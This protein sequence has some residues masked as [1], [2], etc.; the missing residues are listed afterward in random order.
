MLYVG[1]TTSHIVDVISKLEDRTL[2]CSA[3]HGDVDRVANYIVTGSEKMAGRRSLAAIK[4]A[5]I[6]SREALLPNVIG[7]I[8]SV[9]GG[10]IR[11]RAV[12]SET[13]AQSLS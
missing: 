4:V 13:K 11:S 8:E 6:F 2:V 1:P 3:R 12:V 9:S 5:A 7:L 10:P